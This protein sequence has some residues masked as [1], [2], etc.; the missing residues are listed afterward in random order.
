MGPRSEGLIHESWYDP[1]ATPNLHPIATREDN[2]ANTV[3]E[4]HSLPTKYVDDG[5]FEGDQ[6]AFLELDDNDSGIPP[7]E[8]L[9]EASDDECFDCEPHESL[10]RC[11][12]LTLST[13]E[14]QT[15][16]GVFGGPLP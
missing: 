16:S 6:I 11:Q 4:P 13:A 1:A 3:L 2:F 10:G 8:E 5:N 7:L 12:R 9:S 15:R 14:S